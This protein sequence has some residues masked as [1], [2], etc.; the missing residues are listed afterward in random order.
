MSV[1]PAVSATYVPLDH[2]RTP[3]RAN[4]PGPSQQLVARATRAAAAA[5]PDKANRAVHEPPFGF[6]HS[7]TTDPGVRVATAKALETVRI[8]P[9]RGRAGELKVI[10][11]VI[12]A[13]AQGRGGVLVIE[14]PPGIGKSRLLTEVLALAE[15][16]GVRALFG[17]AFEY[18]Q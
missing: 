16:D 12:A 4:V 7:G 10:G 5:H 3:G 15:K 1:K 2:P 17:E 9:I 11:A 8:P 14:G 18:Q 13:V 6:R